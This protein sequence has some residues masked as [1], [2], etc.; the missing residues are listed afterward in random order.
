MKELYSFTVNLEKE[1]EKTETKEEDGKT[2]TVTQKVKEEVPIKLIIKQPSRKNMEDADL[3][4]SIEMSSCIKKG[5]LTRGMLMKKYADTG[6]VLTESDAQ[7]MLKIYANIAHL[8]QEYTS[9]IARTENRDKEK[10]TKILEQ[11]MAGR[12]RLMQL[13]SSY[14]NLISNTADMIAVN[15][16]IRW[17]CLTLIHKQAMP[18][19]PIEPMFPGYTLEDKIETLHKLDEEQDPLYVK[20]YNK[21]ASFVAFWYYSKDATREDFD[22]L[23][24]DIE[25]GK[26]TRE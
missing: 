15:N 16:V 17:Y 23:N 22:S 19:G 13:E 18:D 10:E 21:L 8:E 7:E 20:T 26:F 25:E 12:Q 9:M 11:I 24:K 3:Q 6:G 2:I 14:S 1:V 4:Y 5:I